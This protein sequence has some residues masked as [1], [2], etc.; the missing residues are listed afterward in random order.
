MD[1]TALPR[2]PDFVKGVINLR[3]KVIP[4]IELRLRF[5]LPEKEY[6]EKTCIVVVEINYDEQNVQIGVI[7]DAVSEVLNVTAEDIQE[8]PKFGVNL[9]TD[10]ILGMANT[11]GKVRTLLDID[12]VLTTDEG[13]G[14]AV[15]GRRM[16]AATAG[17]GNCRGQDI[18]FPNSNNT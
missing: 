13:I 3:G 16:N 11:Q 4:V 18:S 2:T 14:I 9:D 1:I 8:T 6:T 17:R 7:V 12:R 15:L 5:N 10:F